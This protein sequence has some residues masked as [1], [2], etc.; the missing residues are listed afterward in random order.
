MGQ[1]EKYSA[2]A[3]VFRSSSDNGRGFSARKGRYP[4]RRS[5]RLRPFVADPMFW[6]IVLKAGTHQRVRHEIYAYLCGRSC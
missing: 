4:D 2:R 3:E 1:T 6:N 5:W